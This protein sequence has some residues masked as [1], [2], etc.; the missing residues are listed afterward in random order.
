[1]ARESLGEAVGNVVASL[2]IVALVAGLLLSI[3]HNV[4]A[5]DACLGR[6]LIPAEVDGVIV[7]VE[8][9]SIRS[10]QSVDTK[11]NLP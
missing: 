7:C 9:G 1:M 3:A 6:G 5:R 8:R 11:G 4:R 2:V 10:A